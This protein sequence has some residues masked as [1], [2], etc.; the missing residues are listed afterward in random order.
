M[1]LPTWRRSELACAP[2]IY[3]S[4]PYIAPRAPKSYRRGLT[5]PNL[6][7]TRYHCEMPYRYQNPDGSVA[8]S[9]EVE[10]V[11]AGEHESVQ[12]RKDVSEPKKICR[13]MCRKC[14]RW[15]FGAAAPEACTTEG[16]TA[17][18]KD[19]RSAELAP[20][21]AKLVPTIDC[22][23]PLEHGDVVAMMRHGHSVN[24][25]KADSLTAGEAECIGVY[26]TASAKPRVNLVGFVDVAVSGPVRNLDMLYVDTD[27]AGKATATPR[28]ERFLVGQVLDT[29]VDVGGDGK[30]MTTV[31]CII[32]PQQL[33]PNVLSKVSARTAAAVRN[34]LKTSAS[35][36][37]GDT[38]A[39]EQSAR[40]RVDIIAT[41]L[42]STTVSSTSVA[43][44]RVLDPVECDQCAVALVSHR[45]RKALQ[46]RLDG[47]VDTAGNCGDAEAQFVLHHDALTGM[48]QLQSVIGDDMWA[49]M[50][51]SG[52]IGAVADPSNPAS[53]FAIAAA[54]EATGA[55]QLT[56]TGGDTTTTGRE[57]GHDA[58]DVVFCFSLYRRA[59][60]T[61]AST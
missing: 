56:R 3:L 1:K 31:R 2:S 16:C 36:G 26:G 55:F 33:P 30:A 18:G 11:P 38:N 17:V 52:V 59:A 45:T 28:G 35:G 29:T 4:E 37:G 42:E 13:T 41:T 53:K 25:V 9:G 15:T 14:K 20:I 57:P 21:Q 50:D 7:R 32:S 12:S 22:G 6:V 34:H 48:V 43:F 8:M 46:Y 58:T 44:Q 10:A 60:V 24:V 51:Q 40:S 47:G 27:N 49:T 61:V 23:E 19:L 54:P 39:H 5:Q